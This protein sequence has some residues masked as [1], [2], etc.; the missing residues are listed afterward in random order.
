MPTPRDSAFPA[1]SQAGAVPSTPRSRR[2]RRS[3]VGLTV[4]NCAW[5]LAPATDHR[6]PSKECLGLSQKPLSQPART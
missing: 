3:R 4:R 1:L 5:H 6:P 2:A